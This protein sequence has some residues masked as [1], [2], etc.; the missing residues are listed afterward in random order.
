LITPD[1]FVSENHPSSLLYE[2]EYVVVAC[3]K[4]PYAKGRIDR[5][6]YETIPHAIMVPPSKDSRPAE[7]LMLEKA[8]VKRNVELSTFSFSALPHLLTNTARIATVHGHM[9]RI[10]SKSNDLVI[11]EL[12]FETP[13]FRQMM[14]WHSYRDNDPGIVWIRKAFETAA[15]RL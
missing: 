8:G 15:S 9:A 10:A 14:Q 2:D 3:G 1:L 11:H 5:A 12:P 4:G 7:G 13:P 6:A